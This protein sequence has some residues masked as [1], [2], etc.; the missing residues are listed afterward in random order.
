MTEKKRNTTGY[1][2][3]CLVSA[4]AL[5]YFTLF[6]PQA[7]WLGLPTFFGGLAMAMDW[8]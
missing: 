2:I 6:L 1:W 3:L 7:F 5:T 8:V 4:L